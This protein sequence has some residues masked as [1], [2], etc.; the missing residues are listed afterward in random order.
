MA[1][2][3]D[4]VHLWKPPLVFVQNN[5]IF[6]ATWDLKAPNKWGKTLA[7]AIVFIQSLAV[8]HT[9]RY[10]KSSTCLEVDPRKSTCPQNGKFIAHFTRHTDHRVMRLV[11]DKT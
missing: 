1:I 10:S 3:A 2:V 9:E 6:N 11:W 8:G 7:L 4:F 5:W